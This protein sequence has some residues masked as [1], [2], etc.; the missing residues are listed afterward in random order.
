MKAPK[1]TDAQKAIILKQGEQGIPVAEIA[2]RP[3]SVRRRTSTGR[4]NTPV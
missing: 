2:E 4:K 1:F 3:G